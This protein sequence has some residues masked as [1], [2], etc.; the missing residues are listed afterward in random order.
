MGNRP[1][2]ALFVTHDTGY[3]GAARSLHALLSRRPA[4]ATELLV[5]RSLT[6]RNDL[7]AIAARFGMDAAAVW[8]AFLPFDRC[9]MGKPAPTMRSRV[10]DGLFRLSRHALLQNIERRRFDYVH[11]NSLVLHPLVDKRVPF[12]VHVREIYDGSRPQVFD[13]LARATGVIFIDEATRDPFRSLAVPHVVL[14]NPFDIGDVDTAAVD[15]LRARHR[16]GNK[17]VFAMVGSVNENKGSAFVIDCFRRAG[18]SDAALV[19]VGEGEPAYE[20]RCREIA[21][22]LDNVAFH[23]FDRDIAALYGASDYVIRAEAYACVGRTIYEGLYAGC[24]VIVPGA[25][26]DSSRMFDF[27]RFR[28]RVH[29]YPPRDTHALATLFRTL[30]AIG[31]RPA[32]ASPNTDAFAARFDDFVS[33]AL[34]VRQTGRARMATA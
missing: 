28:D 22:G 26:D 6:H 11:L 20:A 21:G 5:S 2:R 30:P 1:S 23:G 13:S 10:R 25:I 7:G 17:T 24:S 34:A 19:I 29:F 27:A 12:I 9:F 15:R 4:D 33:S 18:R 16:L 31:R 3:Y 8:E 14:N 32:V